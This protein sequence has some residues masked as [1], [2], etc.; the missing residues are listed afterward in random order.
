VNSMPVSTRLPSDERDIIRITVGSSLRQQVFFQ[1]FQPPHEALTAQSLVN[2]PA[3][4]FKVREGCGH[5]WERTS[6][7]AT[8]LPLLRY[9]QDGRCFAVRKNDVI[10]QVPFMCWS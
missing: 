1:T 3:E 4:I 9:D 6:A 5:N 8:E 10:V 2:L 7:T